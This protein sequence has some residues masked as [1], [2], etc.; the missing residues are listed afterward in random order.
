MDEVLG[1]RPSIS[2]PVLIA[3]IQEDSQGPSNTQGQGQ[4]EDQNQ[5]AGSRK[6]KAGGED[7]WLQ[8]IRE[9]IAFQRPDGGLILT[10]QPSI[11]PTAFWKAGWPAKP[12]NPLPTSARFSILGS[13]ITLD[14]M[15]TTSSQTRWTT[16]WTV[17]QGIPKARDTTL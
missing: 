17:A 6:R 5:Q 11:A 9:D 8:L 16:R 1:Q 15:A 14:R 10:W 7:E 2:P 12:A 3:S 13:R 4:D